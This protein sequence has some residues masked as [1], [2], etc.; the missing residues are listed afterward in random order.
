[1]PRQFV[2]YTQEVSFNLTYCFYKLIISFNTVIYTN[3]YRP[4]RRK[5]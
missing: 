3:E 2:S 4:N 1:M 5:C